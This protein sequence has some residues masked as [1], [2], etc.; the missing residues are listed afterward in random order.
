MDATRE[1]S[2]GGGTVSSVEGGDHPAR[3]VMVVGGGSVAMGGGDG[4]VR[5]RHGHRGVYRALSG[6]SFQH[7]DLY[8]RQSSSCHEPVMPAEEDEGLDSLESHAHTLTPSPDLAQ[9]GVVSHHPEHPGHAEGGYFSLE[10]CLSDE[11]AANLHDSLE[12]LRMQHGAVRAHAHHA[13]AAAHHAHPYPPSYPYPNYQQP[14]KAPQQSYG[15]LPT[16]VNP[17]FQHH[18]SYVNPQHCHDYSSASESHY[19]S[20]S[21]ARN[22]SH[23][24]S[25]H[26]SPN[27]GYASP[28]FQH[29]HQHHHQHQ[30][31]HPHSRENFHV[32]DDGVGCPIYDHPEGYQSH[33]A[34]PCT[35]GYHS[36]GSYLYSSYPS[37]VA[38]H[39][40][41]PPT[42]ASQEAAAGNHDND[43][44]RKASVLSADSLEDLPVSPVSP[45][46]P[47]PTSGGRKSCCYNDSLEDVRP[48]L[49]SELRDFFERQKS[50]TSTS[51]PDSDSTQEQKTGDEDPCDSEDSQMRDNISTEVQIDLNSSASSN[52]TEE[53]S[54]IEEEEEEVTPEATTMESSSEDPTKDLYET[55]EEERGVRVTA[56]KNN[57]KKKP[58]ENSTCQ[59][60]KTTR[61]GD[62]SF[63]RATQDT[64]QTLL[65]STRLVQA[66]L[67]PPAK[68]TTFFISLESKFKV[69]DF[70]G[71]SNNPTDEKG[72]PDDC[73]E[74]S[75]C[76]TNDSKEVHVSSLGATDEEMAHM[77]DSQD[78]CAPAE[79]QESQ[80]I[81]RH[82]VANWE[83]ESPPND[84]S[85]IDEF[86]LV[87]DSTGG[88]ASFTFPSGSSSMI[89]SVG[90]SISEQKSDGN[91]YQEQDSYD[92]G[93]LADVGEPDTTSSSG[94]DPVAETTSEEE[95]EGD[96]AA[97]TPDMPEA[98]E[99]KDGFLEAAPHK[100]IVKPFLGLGKGSS[101]SSQAGSA[102]GTSQTQSSVSGHLR[103]LQEV[104]EEEEEVRGSGETE[105][106]RQTFETVVDI[107]LT[108]SDDD[109]EG[110]SR[111]HPESDSADTLLTPQFTNPPS[112]SN[113]SCASVSNPSIDYAT[114][115]DAVKYANDVIVGRD[116]AMNS[117]ATADSAAAP[118]S[119]VITVSASNDD[120]LSKTVDATGNIRSLNDLSEKREFEGA[121]FQV[122]S[123]VVNGKSLS[124]MAPNLFMEKK[125]DCQSKARAKD[126]ES[127]E[128]TDSCQVDL[129][130]EEKTKGNSVIETEDKRK[131]EITEFSQSK[132][133]KEE[134][135]GE[136]KEEEREEL[137]ASNRSNGLFRPPAIDDVKAVDGRKNEVVSGRWCD[138]QGGSGRVSEAS[139]VEEK[140]EEEEEERGGGNGGGALRREGVNIPHVVTRPHSA[141]PS[142]P[143]TPHPPAP[144]LAG[145]QALASFNT[146]DFTAEVQPTPDLD[147]LATMIAERIISGTSA[148]L[149]STSASEQHWSLPV[150]SRE[151]VTASATTS[152]R[153]LAITSNDIARSCHGLLVSGSVT[154][155]TG[156]ESATAISHS[157]TDSSSSAHV[158]F[159]PVHPDEPDV[160]AESESVG[161]PS[162]PVPS[163]SSDVSDE[164]LSAVTSS[165]NSL[166]GNV[167][168]KSDQ[169]LGDE[170][171]DVVAVQKTDLVTGCDVDNE[172]LKDSRKPIAIIDMIDDSSDGD[173]I[174]EEAHTFKETVQETVDDLRIFKF[175]H[176]TPKIPG[177]KNSDEFLAHGDAECPGDEMNRK[178]GILKPFYDSLSN[179]SCPNSPQYEAPK[180]VFPRK[181]SQG[182]TC[183]S[184]D[185]RKTS[186]SSAI[187][188]PEDDLT[189]LSPD[190]FGGRRLS[191]SSGISSLSD[192]SSRKISLS[193]SVSDDW[194][195]F[196]GRKRSL[197]GLPPW[198]IAKLDPSCDSGDK[199]VSIVSTTSSSGVSSM[200]G[201][202]NESNE[203]ESRKVSLSSGISCLSKIKEETK[204]IF[205]EESCKLESFEQENRQG[206]TDG[207]SSPKGIITLDGKRLTLPPPV[208]PKEGKQNSH[209]VITSH[210]PE[211]PGIDCDEMVLPD[212]PEFLVKRA[213]IM[214]NAQAGSRA[215]LKL[216]LP[217][218][219]PSSCPLK[220]KGLKDDRAHTHS[221][222][223]VN[224]EDDT[225]KDRRKSLHFV[226][227]VKKTD[228]SSA[229]YRFRRL[230]LH[231]FEDIAQQWKKMQEQDRE[232]SE[233][234]EHPSSI[235][236][237]GSRINDDASARNGNPTNTDREIEFRRNL[238]RDLE[239]LEAEIDAEVQALEVDGIHKSK[240]DDDRTNNE[241]D[242]DS[243]IVIFDS[244]ESVAS[245][246]S[247]SREESGGF[248]P[249]DQAD[250]TTMESDTDVEGD[251]KAIES[252]F[253]HFDALRNASDQEG[254]GDEKVSDNH[255]SNS[256]RSSRELKE[257]GKFTPVSDSKSLPN[258]LE[259][260]EAN[261]LDDVTPVDKDTKSSRR[262]SLK[263]S[264]S[265]DTLVSVDEIV[266]CSNYEFSEVTFPTMVGYDELE[267]QEVIENFSDEDLI[268]DAEFEMFSET[269]H[270]TD[271]DNLNLEMFEPNVSG[272]NDKVDGKMLS[273]RQRKLRKLKR[274]FSFNEKP[275]SKDIKETISSSLRRIKDAKFKFER[276]VQKTLKPDSVTPSLSSGESL[277]GSNASQVSAS[278]TGRHSSLP[279]DMTMSNQIPL[280]RTDSHSSNRTSI[281]GSFPS[282]SQDRSDSRT[283][284]LVAPSLSSG[285]V[286]RSTSKA[287]D[288]PPSSES[289]EMRHQEGQE[290][291]YSWSDADSDFE[292]VAVEPPRTVVVYQENGEKAE[293][294]DNNQKGLSVCGSGNENHRVE[295][296][297]YSRPPP[298]LSKWSPSI[299]R[300]WS[301][302]WE[303]QEVSRSPRLEDRE[304]R[305]C[306]RASNSVRSDKVPLATWEPFFC[307]LLQD[308][309]TFT[310]YRSEEMAVIPGTPNRPRAHKLIGDSLFYDLPRMRLDGGA[311]AFRRRWGYELTPPPTLV[312]EDEDDPYAIP[313]EEDHEDN[314]SY[315]ETRS[316]RDDY[317]FHNSQDT[318]YEKACGSD[319]R[320]SAPATPILGAR[321]T[322]STP[323][324][325]VN[326]FSKRSFKSNPLKR[327][328]SVTKLERTRRGGKGG[329]GGLLE[330]DP[331][332][333]GSATARLRSSRSHESLLSSHN[334]MNTLDLAAGEV[335]IKPLH[336]SILGQEHCFQVTSPTGT[337]YFSC[338]TADER[339]RWV[340]SLRKAVNPN[341][342][343]MR[344]TENSLKI[345]ILEAKGVANKKKYFCELLLDNSLYARTSSK[346]KCEMCFWGEQFEFHNLPSVENI[347]VALYREGEKKR[348]K[349]KS[350]LVGQV[351]IPVSNVT[352][353]SHI[354]KWY[355]VQQDRSNTKEQA[356]LRIKCK[357]QSIDILPMELYCDFLQYMKNNYAV[358]CEVLE[359]VI[360]VKAKEDIATALVHVMQ[361]E[362]L[363]RNFLADLVMMEIERIDDSHLLFRGN[364]L[365]T[366][367]ME[368][369]M[370]L[371]GDKYL[372]DTLRQVVNKVVEAGLDCEV[373]PM[374]VPQI[375]S[376]QKQQENLLSIVRMTWSRVLNSHPYFP[377]ELRECF[378]LYRERLAS[379]GKASLSDNLI[380]ASIFLRFLCPAILSPS[381]FNITQEYPDERASRN[382][383]LIAKTLQTL[384]NFTKFQGKENFM[385]FMNQFIEMEQAQM[386]TFLKQIS[387]PATHDHRVLE[388]DKDIDVGKELSLLHTFLSEALRKLSS[389]STKVNV[390][391][392]QQRH[393]EKLRILLDE[394]SVAQTQPNINIVQRL[395]SSHTPVETPTSAGPPFSPDAGMVEERLGYQSLQR[396][397]FRYNDP[398]VSDD[399]RPSAPAPSQNLQQPPETPST[400]RPSTLPRNTYLMGSARKPAVD[401]NT[402]DDYVLYSALEPDCKPKELNP[403]GHSCSYSHLPAEA[404]QNPSS[405]VHNHG[406]GHHHHFHNH[407][408]WYNN[409][410]VFNGHPQVN[411]HS[412][413]HQNGHMVSNG[414]P[415]ESLDISHEE[416][417][418]NSTGET[419]ANMKGSQTSIS[420]LSNVASS[421][422]QSFA[423][424]QS[425]SPVDPSITHH[426]AANNNAAVNNS[427][428]SNNSGGMHISPH[429][430]PPQHSAPLAFNN[431]MYNLDATSSP[432]PVPHRGPR[433]A[434]HHHHHHHHLHQGSQQQ[435]SP[436]S[437]SLS[438]AHSVEDLQSVPPL[439]PGMPSS[440]PQ[441][442]HS[443]SSEDST[444][445]VC[446]PPL[447]HRAFKSGAPRTNPRCL[448]PGRSQTQMVASS[449]PDHHHSTSDLLGG[450]QCRRTKASRR[451]SA[452]VG[453]GRRQRYQYDSD[454]SSDEQQPP[455]SRVRP[456]RVNHRVSETKTLDE[457]EQEILALRTAMEEMHHKLVSADEHVPV[458]PGGPELSPTDVAQS[459][460]PE[461]LHH[462]HSSNRLSSSPPVQPASRFQHSRHN[463][464]DNQYHL[465]QH[466]MDTEVQSAHMRDLIQ[467]KLGQ[468]CD[469]KHVP[470]ETSQLSDTSDYKSSS[471]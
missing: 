49:V 3:A 454:S 237:D 354:E 312:E 411:G 471:C 343:N 316:L 69:P 219:C 150:T 183:E 350:F 352:S 430:T 419:E 293:K 24:G 162:G 100:V 346:Q 143:R 410:Q 39:Q 109:E 224:D 286:S 367:A 154:A 355:Q 309:T 270:D 190:A 297:G 441:R 99:E 418:R 95:T 101:R 450:A 345:F 112:V 55:E 180:P 275:P 253:P 256:K 30:L 326:F 144:S 369:F 300:R 330:S 107:V 268:S 299:Q 167:S 273:K 72:K 412:Q 306:H 217:L 151:T 187:T 315:T 165:S 61:L 208:W 323:N 265:M 257:S 40:P 86:F 245:A 264:K 269:E 67:K 470:Q 406:H 332:S 305:L 435:Q 283:S 423:Y 182:S 461:A 230:T 128:K 379:I 314:L 21:M 416:N 291:A 125:A 207:K 250:D 53:R 222:C 254:V 127:R 193:S 58:G 363:A 85:D 347:T 176:Q 263:S 331:L 442:A 359:P 460:I 368:A 212:V 206:L 407:A 19:A 97:A 361:R 274:K 79:Y 84:D 384:A 408:G 152:I 145:S 133:A 396:N 136:E 184:P 255:G 236:K 117:N 432:R 166:L 120:T 357:F 464:Q 399:Y 5:G 146:F 403:L 453:S 44:V 276:L 317:L 443:S 370:K 81:L 142:P 434:Y 113:L 199:K 358:I 129:K 339:D 348:K 38:H 452:E 243:L 170:G 134:R 46:S 196:P 227:R 64:P 41:A 158:A 12:N 173:H 334:M 249:L 33:G 417:D 191:T 365:A 229:S 272:N 289:W 93:N 455:P 426:D 126:Y 458:R 422:Y 202:L 342:D 110:R 329:V 211:T 246:G 214:R 68:N 186:F 248:S 387:S 380:S 36:K 234:T 83:S 385:E 225:K 26:F 31:H 277:E 395:S 6:V 159:T 47:I 451:Q 71:S 25:A 415:E 48:R 11:D 192:M 304:I 287:S 413:P 259:V 22:Y 122:G 429:L 111:E 261:I 284:D 226:P 77:T 376:L 280:D 258:L 87:L 197:K 466:A 28:V 228:N 116:S 137:T 386:K 328:K 383:T 80:L 462:H 168:D 288:D 60:F 29:H 141:P 179:D 59:T 322:D 10:R 216:D 375:S 148:H 298:P 239:K 457:Y 66:T 34:Y 405:P 124:G 303:K 2:W 178:V 400:P 465:P 45:I 446:T 92:D 56:D 444:S 425:S 118:T 296:S 445:L 469:K 238:V 282:G 260:G 311:R 16:Y 319:R 421:G 266:P 292:F 221:H 290:S 114:S 402:A 459:N 149:P 436:V 333:L 251:D 447:E 437:S 54:S 278:S 198:D 427:N 160:E 448:P 43:A 119:V 14:H 353:R 424:S 337:R 335:T 391:T 195:W 78:T 356:A 35:E 223:N 393:L 23:N 240:N 7:L 52:K 8:V 103:P 20:P 171:S 244:T 215:E 463:H 285:G 76:S 104:E 174:H 63:L 89:S 185:S 302:R 169:K 467:K 220:R 231:T 177:N 267:E 13:P 325:L 15:P 17:G 18:P 336:A 374:K 139:F 50:T 404:A 90:S 156:C 164:H 201:S 324:R 203:S 241:D 341:Y 456:P 279:R 131:E 398:T 320:G 301:H 382:L 281:S 439:T 108:N 420:Q 189:D 262:E 155:G 218:I 321:P 147:A 121:E 194:E 313:H 247:F 94:L 42:S 409:R 51:S 102:L 388:Y 98:S 295:A 213:E 88:R 373:D 73:D 91:A 62:V 27:P 132:P 106:I 205:D 140:E 428:S 204:I 135:G 200:T 371:V 175:S 105:E 397:I 364:S 362:G 123:P 172:S 349:E 74:D 360:S 271:M 157:L 163:V 294:D 390:N 389:S 431:P 188:T 130:S 377:L 252:E 310:A 433:L 392:S 327:T 381:L 75:S 378:C 232:I 233:K 32:V 344:R 209:D 1:F 366:K 181:D 449:A 440:R 210:L 438:S 65:A 351:N 57:E 340:D 37:R 372:L 318:S 82:F 138:W 468:P 394:V 307:V 4:S 242:S 338:R 414:N 96:T 401:L 153:P 9:G 308:E 70:E 235:V 115:C 161:T